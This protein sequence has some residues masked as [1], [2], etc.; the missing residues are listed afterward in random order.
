MQKKD[1]KEILYKIDSGI[2]T[3]EEEAAV[4]YWLHQLNQDDQVTF[5]EEE[6]AQAGAEVWAKLLAQQKAPPQKIVSIWSRISGIAAAVMLIAFGIYFFS[7]KNNK[8]DA[9][10]ANDIAPG[11]IG[12]TLTLTNGK[13]IL[14]TNAA[15]GE[16]AK[17]AG[18]MI[19]K[20]ANGELVYEIIGAANDPDK[21]NTL[22]TANGETYQLRLPDGSL[23]F[24]NAA[25]SL[26][27]STSLTV[28]GKRT[29]TLRGEAYFQVAKDKAH[30]FI[31]KTKKQ[32]I[33]VLG[34]HFNVD[35]YGDDLVEKTTLLEGSVRISSAGGK[36][37]L[38]PGEQG[39]LEGG[40]IRVAEVDTDLAIAW[41]NGL[42]VF[43]DEP[44]Q[45]VMRRVSRWYDVQVSYEGVD[46]NER[47]G[48]SV[49]RYDNVSKVLKK[50]ELTGGIHF[51]IEGR[52]ITVMK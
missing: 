43:D 51:K 32:E 20:S 35:S 6:I 11:K 21:T 39:R 18:I 9:T 42:F 30:P 3:A 15:N 14:L 28:L 29:V 31:V 47:Y 4:K 44:L 19:T 24:L 49:S 50:L 48:G 27:Y 13:K 8:G 36:A 5:T 34:T 2:Y 12:A 41:K 38:K 10:Y 25:S 52:N 37:I 22:T 26:T 45:N 7:L 16:I 1:I 23:V 40:A 33:E 46:K 17:E